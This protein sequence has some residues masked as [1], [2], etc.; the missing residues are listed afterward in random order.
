MSENGITTAAEV[1]AYAESQAWAP[2]E[3]VPLPHSGLAVLLRKPTAVYWP[4]QRAAWPAG[5][6]EKVWAADSKED[7][8]KLLTREETRILLAGQH[9]MLTEAFVEPK[10]SFE[11]GQQFH[12]SLFPEDDQ[13]FILR[14]LRGQV[15]AD[16]T[17]LEA[18]RT[19]QPGTTGDGGVTGQPLPGPDPPA[20]FGVTH[21]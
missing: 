11:P 1:R 12:W 5:L 6:R 13:D 21:G 7:L 14:Y 16:G 19:Q 4:L 3:R 10:V 20:V 18:F 2:A 8:A 9:E 17:D 15:C